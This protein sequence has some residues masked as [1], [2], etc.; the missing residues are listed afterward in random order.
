MRRSF[1]SIVAVCLVAMLG[2]CVAAPKSATAPNSPPKRVERVLF[3]GN[4]L[5]YRNDL[6]AHFAALASTALGATVEAEMIAAGGARIEQHAAQGLVQTEL[7]S[8]R[9]TVLVLQEW[10]SGLLCDPEFAKFGFECAASHRAHRELVE[11]ARRNRVRVV[12]LGT[13][14]SAPEPAIALADAEAELASSLGITHA[15]LR[16]LPELRGARPAAEWFDTDG[17]HPGPELTLLMARRLADALHGDMPLPRAVEMQYRDY[18]G[19]QAP[20]LQLLA[21]AQNLQPA[22]RTRRVEPSDWERLARAGRAP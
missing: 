10:G 17:H 12:L 11:V 9:Y 5:T 7:A 18:R 6:P 13:Y 4:S 16:D 20:K 21:S 14:S 15:D 22:Q 2:A 8:G 1:L 3:V 19:E